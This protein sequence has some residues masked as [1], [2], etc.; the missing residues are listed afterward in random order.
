MSS[1]IQEPSYIQ[2]PNYIQEPSYKLEKMHILILKLAHMEEIL[3]HL[4][5]MH[6]VIVNLKDKVQ[7][8]E[9]NLYYPNM[10]E[11]IIQ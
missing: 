5:E 2:M 11:D 8:Q 7:D 1:C 9:L 3:K 6:I 10:L 4:T